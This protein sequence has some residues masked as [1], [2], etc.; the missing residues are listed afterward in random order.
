MNENEN[1][2]RCDCGVLNSIEEKDCGGC[3]NKKPVDEDEIKIP[4][5]IKDITENMHFRFP[6]R[7]IPY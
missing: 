5:S 7:I 4:S 1:S 3:D 6:K 2:W